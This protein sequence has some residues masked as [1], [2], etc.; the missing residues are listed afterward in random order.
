MDV[1]SETDGIA[2]VAS[3][4]DG[5]MDVASETDGTVAGID[6]LAKQAVV[7]DDVVD[8][9]TVAA[10]HL[11]LLFT[12]V[13]LEDESSR[14]TTG[15][16]T[17]LVLLVLTVAADEVVTF[18]MLLVL[19]V[20]LTVVVVLEEDTVDNALLFAL[21]LFIDEPRVT[22]EGMTL[23][24]ILLTIASVLDNGTLINVAAVFTLLVAVVVIPVDVLAVLVDALDNDDAPD[25]RALD[26]TTAADITVLV[27]LFRPLV[28]V[29]NDATV[30]AVLIVVVVLIILTA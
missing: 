29:D 16:M 18:L 13:A 10:I 23:A 24:L 14:E 15:S 8:G 3:E 21:L 25:D 9:T 27:L 28:P 11:A 22:T 17:S 5:I 19:T 1:A 26:K 12:A 30:I 7:P 20:V 2:D 4:T 6:L